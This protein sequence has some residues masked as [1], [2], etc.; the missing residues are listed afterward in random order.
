MPWLRLWPRPWPSPWQSPSQG[1][2]QGPA[3]C[4]GQCLG[5]G[6]GQ[7][8]AKAL[9]KGIGVP[10]GPRISGAFERFSNTF[11]GPSKSPSKV[12]MMALARDMGVP[13]GRSGLKVF[14][15]ILKGCR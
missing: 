13:E 11:I 2:G 3:Q 14:R 5:Q 8:L 9:A 12:F 1:S 6:L 4:A 7:G 10:K 15:I